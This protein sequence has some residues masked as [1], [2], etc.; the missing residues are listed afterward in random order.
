MGYPSSPY[1]TPSDPSKSYN[2]SFNPSCYYLHVWEDI[3]L[4]GNSQLIHR[5]EIEIKLYPTGAYWVKRSDSP[6]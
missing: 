6:S 3:Y 4:Q 1:W 2:V 5:V